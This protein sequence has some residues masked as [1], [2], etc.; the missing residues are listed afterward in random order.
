MDGVLYVTAIGNSAWAVDARTGR[1]I[2]RY[3]RSLPTPL[4]VCCGQVNHGFGILGDRLF[5]GTLDAHLVALDRKTGAVLWD[6]AAAENKDGYSITLAPLVVKDKVIVGI[7]GGDYASRGF[8]DAYDAADRQ[9]R[10]A[11][12]Y[13]S[14]AGRAGQPELAGRRGDDARRRRRLRHRQLRSGAEPRLLRHRQP[15]SAVLRRATA[16]ATICTPARWSRSMPRPGRCGG[17][18]SSRRTTRTTGIPRTC[19]CSPT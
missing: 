15:E 10:L 2:W 11:V 6:V 12:P 8:I 17:T 19:R 4:K 14:G 3:R 5:M 7:A 9:A 16:R 13:H 18:F 1:S